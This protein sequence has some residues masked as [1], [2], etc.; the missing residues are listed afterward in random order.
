M[1]KIDFLRNPDYPA[2]D[3]GISKLFIDMFSDELL[4]C[5]DIGW[6]IW[7]GKFW[8]RDA[9]DGG[10][11]N[12]LVKQ[13]SKYCMTQIVSNP[14][15]NEDEMESLNKVY[16]KLFTKN[17]RDT[18]IRDAMSIAP[19]KSSIFDKHKFLFNC[20]NGT[21]DFK[22]KI[23]RPFDKQDYLTD[24]SNV[25][26]RPDATCPR[27]EQYLQEV[28]DKD[29][30]KIDYLLKIA[31]Y[32]MTGDTSRECF[33]IL[34]GDKTRNGKGT[35]VSTFTQLMGTY[36]KTLKA[37]S[38]TK[39]QLNSGG[40]NATPDLAKLKNAR[41][42][43]VNEIEDGMMLDIA[44]MKEMTG[45]DTI[46]AR[47]LYKEEFD[48]VPQFKILINTNVLPK[49][50]EDSIFR[51]NRIHLICF[52]RHFEENERDLNLKDKLKAELSGIFNLLVPY[53]D[54]LNS[55]GFVLPQSTKDTI[56]QYQYN[57]NNVLLFVK[58]KLYEDKPTWE[59][60]TD[61]YQTYC[62]WCDKDGLSQ[63]SKKVFKERLAKCGATIEDGLA[64]RYNSKGESVTSRGWVKGYSLTKPKT[65]QYELEEID[66][67]S[68]PF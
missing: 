10:R 62:D 44:L 5:Q 9:K 14:K 18:V 38:I 20:Q 27:F 2:N 31:A 1:K 40:S 35:F 23:F 52:D 17:Y 51:S 55:E 68:L 28:M 60:M 16:K 49:M 50:S 56:E 63:M 48:F 65:Q 13:M 33:F 19:V 59:T 36:A 30:S 53:Y 6:Y 29:N 54:K 22:R 26:Y 45:G 42:A 15:L 4:F 57:S 66:D 39:K 67:D 43:N 37:A 8:E 7:N 41:L 61:I 11:V 34:Y 25:E 3:I 64:R 32:C 46:T 58:E 47:F 12:E 21:Y 24:I